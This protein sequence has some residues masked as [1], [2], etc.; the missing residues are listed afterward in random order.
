MAMTSYEKR[1]KEY[2]DPY[3]KKAVA[4][5]RELYQ[6][7]AKATREYYDNQI[8]EEGRAYEDQYRENAVQKAINERQVDESMA[9]MGLSDSGLNRTQATAINLSYSNNKAAI[10]RAKRQAIDSIELQ[11]TADLSAIRKGWL[12]EKNTINQTYD[13][14]ETDYANDLYSSSGTSSSE[15]SGVYSDAEKTYKTRTYYASGTDEEGNTVYYFTDENGKKYTFKAGINP[16]TGKPITGGY[17]AEEIKD[18]GGV[19]NGYQPKGVK[20]NGYNYGK[21]EQFKVEVKT[22]RGIRYAYPT[23][24][25]QGHEKKVWKTNDGRLWVW[26]DEIGNYIRAEYKNGEVYVDS[27]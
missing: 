24:E 10:D 15:G 18:Y 13:Q 4:D 21:V 9:N 11:K 27:Q 20:Y 7:E 6:Q 16:Y 5:T 25:Y 8:F 22:E 2:I 17:T 26:D 3:R 1:A 19:W 12:A 23:A 14:Y